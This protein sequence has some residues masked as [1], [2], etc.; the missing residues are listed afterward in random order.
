LG[1]P[2]CATAKAIIYVDAAKII[3]TIN[4]RKER[5]NFKN[6]ILK[7][8]THPLILTRKNTS[9]LSRRREEIEVG[10]RRIID[11]NRMWRKF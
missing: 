11:L 1:R 7:A 10:K 4:G 6:K 9:Q 3:F 8:P 5:F 2:F